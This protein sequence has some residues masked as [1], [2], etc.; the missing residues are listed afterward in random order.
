MFSQNYIV[1]LILS[2][3]ASL[4]AISVHEFSH[5][6]AAYKLGDPTAKSIGRLTINPIKHLDPVGT[7]CM[8]FFHF[9]WAR[10][11]PIDPRYFKKPRGYF[12][13]TALAGPMSNILLAFLIAPL[14]LLCS[15]FFVY[16]GN[17]FLNSLMLNTLIFLYTFQIINVGLGVFNLIPLPPFDGSR[18]VNVLLPKK[19]YFKIMKYERYIYFGVIG[20]LLLGDGIYR[21]LIKLSFVSSNAFLSGAVRVFSLSALVSDAISFVSEIIMRFWQLIPPFS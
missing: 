13:I 16:T 6:Y 2:L 8:V 19:W 15:K 5:A 11:V 14:Y 3:A 20:W 18:I 21:W 4:L 1:Q 10:P 17:A 7:L 9:G 12:A